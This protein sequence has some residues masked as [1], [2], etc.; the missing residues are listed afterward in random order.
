[1]SHNTV[2]NHFTAQYNILTKS[3]KQIFGLFMYLWNLPENIDGIVNPKNKYISNKKHVCT[4]TV[5]RAVKRFVEFGWLTVKRENR[6]KGNQYEIV[7]CIAR[8]WNQ[9]KEND[10][11][12][13][14]PL[15][16]PIFTRENVLSNVSL[17]KKMSLQNGKMSPQ[18]GQNVPSKTVIL[19][20][21]N[22]PS[23]IDLSKEKHTGR[24]PSNK[25][26]SDAQDPS[27][28]KLKALV[29]LTNEEKGIVYPAL[30]NAEKV[31]NEGLGKVMFTS[32]E[33]IEY[34]DKA[35]WKYGIKTGSEKFGEAIYKIVN[36]KKP[37][38]T[39]EGFFTYLIK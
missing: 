37:V 25:F 33:L 5:N 15:C 11:R 26:L 29:N 22:V 9:Q 24:A 17:D 27:K 31:Q 4:K 12:H 2:V 28:K 35:C 30:K 20:V 8:A 10:K 3:Q 14:K 36:H 19:A 21:E 34:C 18:N 7:N 6:R 32:E 39:K 13:R 1:M 23:K 38:D 16:S